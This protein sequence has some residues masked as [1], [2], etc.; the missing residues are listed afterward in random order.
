MLGWMECKARAFEPLMA[1]S[2]SWTSKAISLRFKTR[3]LVRL[4]LRKL[5]GLLI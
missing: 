4:W 2:F 5:A 1:V 3:S